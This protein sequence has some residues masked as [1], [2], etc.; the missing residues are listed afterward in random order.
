MKEFNL[1]ISGVGGQGVITLMR[2][3]AESALKQ[4]YDVKTSELHGLAQRGGHI[5][6][7][8]RFGK[9]IYSPLVR[10]GKANLIF[11]LEP[12]EAMRACYYASRESG[13]VFLINSYRLVPVSSLIAREKYPSS[14]E[15][16]DAIK[17]FSSRVMMINA[18]QIVVKETGSIAPTNVY[19]LG[20]AK[21]NGLI[22]I[23]KESI[24]EGMKEIIRPKYLEMNKK[25]FELSFKH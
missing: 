20:Y 7:H 17:P 5:E 18:S 24:L 4:G 12:L 22:P 9:K 25:V 21:S 10:Q 14:S 15:V 19:M 6:C 13:T 11:G 23:D 1:V 8:V 16:L 2:I 3:I